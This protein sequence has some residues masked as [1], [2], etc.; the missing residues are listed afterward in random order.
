[1][2]HTWLNGAHFIWLV[3]G[4]MIGSAFVSIFWIAIVERQYR[5]ILKYK[6]FWQDYH[7]RS[8]REKG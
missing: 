5:T 6:T 8:H 2:E 7:A 3:A 4:M 1:M